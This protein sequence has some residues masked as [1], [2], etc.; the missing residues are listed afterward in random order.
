MVEKKLLKSYISDEKLWGLDD[1][2]TAKPRAA[3]TQTAGKK[4]VKSSV[5][6]PATA[7][8]NAA[9]SSSNKSSELDKL[10]AKNKNCHKCPLGKSRLNFVFGVGNPDAELMFVGEGPGFDE[11]HKG[12]P[13]VGRAGQLLN[14]IIAAMG[15]AREDVYIANITKCH[16]MIDPSN[17]DK[18]GND[19]PPTGEEM[20]GCMPILEEQMNIIR[21]RVLCAL[22]STAAKGLLKT[23]EAIGKLRGNIFDFTTVS[24][25]GAAKMKLVPT[26]HPAALLRNPALKKICWEDIRL[27]MKLLK[28]K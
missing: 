22:G 4:P 14:K 11:D 20:A 17:P 12:E 16:P 26:Y 24:S 18:R 21:P 15:L 9:G 25:S 28:D 1:F 7:L 5:A 27:V 19:R 3:R 8:K 23:D 6:R 10:L 13:F 2:S